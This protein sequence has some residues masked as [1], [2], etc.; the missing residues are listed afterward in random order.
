MISEIDNHLILYITSGRDKKE[1]NFKLDSL[2][3][4]RAIY[5]EDFVGGTYLRLRSS[6]QATPSSE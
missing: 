2:D 6:E 3:F 4:V 1:A 5:R